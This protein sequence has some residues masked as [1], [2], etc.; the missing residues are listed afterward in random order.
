MNFVKQFLK[1][2]IVGLGELQQSN[3]HHD[4]KNIYLWLVMPAV[5]VSLDTNRTRGISID[6]CWI[7]APVKT[8]GKMFNEDQERMFKLKVPE[9][10]GTQRWKN[11]LSPTKFRRW[12][13]YKFIS[14]IS[15]P[16]IEGNWRETFSFFVAT[17]TTCQ[18]VGFEHPTWDK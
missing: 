17:G 12:G 10:H 16:I 3:Q 2:D 11:S 9:W 8:D 4:R 1:K 6:Q 13:R 14:F 15:Y 5:A 7:R 18:W